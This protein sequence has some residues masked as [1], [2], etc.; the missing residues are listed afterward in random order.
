ME[1]GGPAMKSSD[2]I[3][4]DPDDRNQVAEIAMY[5]DV[6]P[7]SIRPLL[8]QLRD[9]QLVAHRIEQ[10]WRGNPEPRPRSTS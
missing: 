8:Q 10:Y 4:I 9:R 3:T 2:L 1:E 6:D 5:L 7:N